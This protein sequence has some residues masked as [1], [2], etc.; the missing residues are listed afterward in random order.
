MGLDLSITDHISTAISMYFT[1]NSS[2]FPKALLPRVVKFENLTLRNGKDLNNEKSTPE[3]LTCSI[4][5]I[6]IE[7]ITRSAKGFLNKTGS[8]DPNKTKNKKAKVEYL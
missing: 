2:E 5:S 3:K 7:L 4:M 1:L 8:E 6:S